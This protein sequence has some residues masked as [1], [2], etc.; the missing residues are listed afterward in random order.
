MSETKLANM[1]WHYTCVPA[2]GEGGASSGH[3]VDLLC[4]KGSC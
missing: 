1:K 2:A 3:H 4:E